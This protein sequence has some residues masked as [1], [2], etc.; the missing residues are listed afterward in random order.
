[1]LRAISAGDPVACADDADDDHPCAGERV[2]RARALAVGLPAG[3]LGIERYRAATAGLAVGDDPRRAATVGDALVF[4][5][6]GLAL[7]PGSGALAAADGR[8]I[9]VQ[10][11]TVA[12][13]AVV[14]RAFGLLLRTRAPA[15]QA[16]VVGD[17]A[18]LWIMVVGGADRPAHA[19]AL[20]RAVRRPRA[21]E[22]AGLHTTLFDPAAPRALWPRS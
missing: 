19:A 4:A 3:E 6:A 22:L 13:V 20:A 12:T 14:S 15:D 10:G 5:R 8:G 1:M 17:R 2:A 18:A 11:D 7:A 9:V 21:D 16:F